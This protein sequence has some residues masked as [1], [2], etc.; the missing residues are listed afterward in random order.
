MDDPG[1]VEDDGAMRTADGVAERAGTGIVKRGDVVNGA[2]A[3]AGGK[4]A[5]AFGAGE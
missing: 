3:T 2:A 5:E 1:D 4:S